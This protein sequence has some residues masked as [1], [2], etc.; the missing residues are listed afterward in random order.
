[1]NGTGN[2]EDISA[3]TVPQGWQPI[4]T[5]PRDG[6]VV[7]LT[8]M[9][10]GR[11]QEIYPMQWGHIQRNKLFA[12]DTVGMWIMPNGAATWTEHDPDGAPTHWRPESPK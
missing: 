2:V 4:A 11:P 12:G 9:D 3:D 10:N 6:T 7:E 8:W 1:M 5:A